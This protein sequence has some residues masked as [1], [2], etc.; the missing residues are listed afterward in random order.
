MSS[1]SLEEARR[2]ALS[3]EL[4]AAAAGR[5][6]VIG[7]G[8]P[9][10]GDDAFGPTLIQRLWAEG[11]PDGVVLVDGGTAGMDVAFKMRDAEHVV[12][13]DAATTGAT[14]GTVY[15]VPGEELE[16]LPAIDGLHTHQF[17]WDHALA[18]GR[19]LLA[20][21]YPRRVTVYLV[22]AA[23]TVHGAPLSE[24]VA[25]V[26]GDV[27]AMVRAHFDGELTVEFTSGGGVRLDAAAAERYFPGDA[28]VAMPKGEELWLVPLIGTQAGGLL[29]K[30]RNAAGDRAALVAEALQRCVHANPVGIRRATW[31]PEHGAV[32][33]ALRP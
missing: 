3:D 23:A 13:V 5:I 31:D 7:C 12:I 6:V 2:L 27:A 17:R 9:L 33:V 32:R 10:R 22:E 15:R 4:C 26:V 19:W 11:V 16:D 8:N 29:L 30:R 14:P 20:E 28:L 25:A 21:H 18:F 24:P 1:I